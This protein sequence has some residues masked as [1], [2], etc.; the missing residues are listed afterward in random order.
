[1][2]QNIVISQKILMMKM[3]IKKY[4]IY[5][6]AVDG[7]LAVFSFFKG[8]NFFISSQAGFVSSLLVTLSSY[9]GYKQMV[10][11]KI[12]IGD[13][14]KQERDELDCIDD[15]FELYSENEEKIDFQEV[16]NEE[17]KKIKGVK[18]S[19]KNLQKSF[20]AV[21]SPFRIL[22]YIFLIMAFLYLNTHN[23][24]NIYGF[25]LGISVVSFVSLVVGFLKP[26][27]DF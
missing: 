22:S 1:M 26:T 8:S 4:F 14:P 3:N 6:V 15:R 12:S 10:E 25:I 11:N 9:H 7:V 21:I 17:K 24:L 16:V 20:F 23:M 27:T 13:I 18:N 2:I 19:A 5:F